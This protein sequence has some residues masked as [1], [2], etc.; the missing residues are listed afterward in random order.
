MSGSSE[1]VWGSG[2]PRREFLHVDDL[3]DAAVHLM[4]VYSGETPVNVGTGRDVTIV[5]LAQGIR[6]VTRFHGRMVYDRSKPDG[7][8]RKCLDVTRLA[9]IG[10]RAGIDLRTGLA[11]TYRWFGDAAEVS[12]YRAI[13]LCGVDRAPSSNRSLEWSIR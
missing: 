4:E 5:E 1:V 6:E 13:P 7:A 2:T 10:W 8:P 3:V 9:R 12:S 11:D